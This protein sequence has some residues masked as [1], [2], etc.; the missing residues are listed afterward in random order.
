MFFQKCS[1]NARIF[2]MEGQKS[3]ELRKATGISR[4]G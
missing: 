3:I 2:D 1:V 4:N